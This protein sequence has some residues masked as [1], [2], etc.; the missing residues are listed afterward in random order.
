MCV[1][2][3]AVCVA[4]SPL[5]VAASPLTRAPTCLLSLSHLRGACR[6][7]CSGLDA[8][9]VFA[10]KVFFEVCC[11]R[12]SRLSARC[13][14]NA[15]GEEARRRRDYRSADAIRDALTREHDVTVDDEMREWW[16]GPRKVPVSCHV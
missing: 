3:E 8:C 7:H 4:A 12:V 15:A 13:A 6:W 2:H 14:A 16:C 9:T 10:V 1:A 5:C 11:S